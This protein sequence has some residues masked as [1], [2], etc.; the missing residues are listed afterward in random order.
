MCIPPHPEWGYWI[1]RLIDP[2]I[3]LAV[4]LRWRLKAGVSKVNAVV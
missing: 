3:A 2:R 4:K 1:V